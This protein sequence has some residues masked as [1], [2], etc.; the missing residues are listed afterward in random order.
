MLRTLTQQT[1][2]GQ[3]EAAVTADKEAADKEAADKEA[4]AKGSG[5]WMRQP[6]QQQGRG[7][8]DGR[9]VRPASVA[10]RQ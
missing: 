2:E 8:D 4:A 3:K 7:A 5:E 1:A 9:R 6:Q 10:Q